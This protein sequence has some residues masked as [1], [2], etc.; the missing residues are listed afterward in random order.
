MQ[1]SKV[2]IAGKWVDAE[3]GKTFAVYSPSTGEELGRVPLCGDADVDKAVKAAVDAFPAWARTLQSERSKIVARLAGAIREHAEEFVMLEVNEHG[4]PVQVARNMVAHGADHGDYT[5]AISR[6][7]M[8]QVIPAIPDTLSYLQ[9]VPIG[10]CSVITPWNV[11]FLMMVSTIAPTIAVGNTCILKPA[12]INSLIAVKFAEIVE[13]IGLPPG[14]V[15]LVTGPGGSVGKALAS[16]P[17]VDLVRFTGSSDTGKEIMSYASSTVKKVVLE[18]GGNNPV[19]VFD[20]ADVDKAAKSHAPRH[21]GNTAQNCSTPGR[22][23]VHE[24]VYDEFVEK[25]VGEVKKI[26]VGDPRDEKTTMGPMTNKQ[27]M[28]RV[29]YLIKTA[30]EEGAHIVV[31][32]G[33]A[34]TP[35]LDKGNFLMPT[36]AVDVTHDMTIAREE[37]FG[38]AACIL[39][40]SDKDDIIALA[41]DT[42]FGLCAVV[43]TK[44]MAKG[45][46]CIN[47]LR[48]DSVYLNM[49]R[50]MAAELPW[51]GNIKESGVGKSDSMCG[52][53]E[54]TEL[55]QV[56]ISYSK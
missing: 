29:E 9:R 40:F 46:R 56:C 30:R 33:R 51:G 31:G 22:Y 45:L 6:A 53:E 54:L 14:V 17:G 52:M 48:V 18:L 27:Q 32:G 44:D 3:S 43:W 39:K 28:E 20:D 42:T 26:V 5:I 4:T 34:T 41:N 49:P 7:L 24:K 10:V 25:F 11:P 2:W 19:I 8:G 23:Y 16:H 15:N 50:T 35:P 12:S 47:E 38:P 37:I 55:K 13:K 36:V 21:F 1:N